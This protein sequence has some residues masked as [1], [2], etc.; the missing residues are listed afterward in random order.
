[1]NM[2]LLQQL[3]ALVATRNDIG[4]RITKL[5]GR[6][7]QIGHL[8]EF[9]A[10]EIFGIS[11][12]QSAANKGFDGR[13]RTGPFAGRTVDVKWYAKREGGVDLRLDSLPDFDL[14]LVGPA[15]VASSSRGDDRPWLLE[16]VHL[17]DANALVGALRARGLKV[18]IATSVAR[19]H[20]DQAEIY[21]VPRN[22]MLTLSAGQRQAL[23]LFGAA[24]Q[25]AR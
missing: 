15:G 3:A 25:S 13:F 22:N 21:P 16:G 8:G 17:F 9:I 4:A 18:G 11:L 6:P 2:D 12:E 24:N 23:K 7:S 14:V 10:A 1:M 5:T 19:P 20:W